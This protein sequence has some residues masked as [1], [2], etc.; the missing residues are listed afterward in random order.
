MPRNVRNIVLMRPCN[1]MI[2]FKQIIGRGTR[3]YDGKNYFT[4]YDFV[5]AHQNFADPEWDGE[6]IPQEPDHSEPQPSPEGNNDTAGNDNEPEPPPAETI[7]IQLS[8]GKART[9]RHISSAMY[10]STDGTPITAKEFVERMSD[11]LPRFFN[12]EEE[13]RKLWSDP[14]TREKLLQ[15]LAEAGY[16]TEKLNSM[17]DLIDARDSDVYDVLAFVA[18]AAEPRTRQQR[19]RSAKP[20]IYNAFNYKQQVFIEFILEKYIQDGVQE[21]AETK[22]RHLLE[23]KYHTLGDAARELGSTRVIRDT[24]IGFQKY[25]YQSAV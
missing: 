9:I 8:D 14:T 4:L 25:L 13:L 21:L 1:N 18:Y 7:T 2:E 11:D 19:V 6:P 22:L 16:D 20:A 5:K 23:L 12:N 24:F 15:N 3:L 10:W 17:K